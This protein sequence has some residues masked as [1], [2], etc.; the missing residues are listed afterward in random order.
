LKDR[1]ENIM[2]NNDRI[3]PVVR[4]DLLT[5]LGT[6]FKIAGTTI[7]AAESSAVGEFT[8]ASA[9]GNYIANEPVRKF[10]FASGTSAV[11]YFIADY[12]YDGF[13]IANSK[14]TTSGTAVTA[15]GKTLYSATLSGGSAVAIAKVGF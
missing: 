9:S 3:V 4:T 2:I 8:V 7:A 6:M 5:L 13:Y 12:E 1:E 11:V 15:D 14:V 10:N